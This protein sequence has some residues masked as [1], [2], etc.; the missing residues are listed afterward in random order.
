MAVFNPIDRSEFDVD[1]MDADALNQLPFG[2]IKLDAEGRIFFYN[3][4]ESRL[5]GRNPER[6]I[7]RRFFHE[8]APCTNMPDFYGRFAGAV[9]AQRTQVSFTFVFDFAM[10]PVRVQIDMSPARE[11]GRYWILVRPVE[12]LRP[13]EEATASRLLNGA[14]V[15][16]VAEAVDTTICDLELIHLPDAIQPHGALLAI[17]RENLTL[18]AA[19]RNLGELMGV[20]LEQVLGESADK[21]FERSFL[22][23]LSEA[24]SREGV[25]DRGAI[26]T[27][28]G[29]WLSYIAHQSGASL[30]V[31]LQYDATPPDF[32]GHRVDAGQGFR[33]EF[34][35]VVLRA[36]ASDY[37]A[38][39]AARICREF[40]GFD[41]VLIYQ[42]D[43]AGGGSVIAEE[44]VTDWEQSLIGLEFPASDIPKQAR[45][46][47]LR[48]RVRHIPNN[49]YIPVDLL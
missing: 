40:S 17:D 36:S 14:Q 8:V 15:R 31:E 1:G 24:T 6:V 4:A 42:F 35:D 33:D 46:L 11:V 12:Y 10:R 41:R 20:P 48:N 39:D 23:T 38:Q 49:A 44:K 16:V 9:V 43:E 32:D 5:S 26:R 27:K 22:K 2:A 28:N 18:S 7:G 21:L 25:R 37:V 47:Y 13:E 34:F 45:A 3:K 30:I 19:S 29:R